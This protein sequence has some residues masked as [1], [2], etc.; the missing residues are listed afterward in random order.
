[1]CIVFFIL[2][3]ALL[4]IHVENFTDFHNFLIL[5]L[6]RNIKLIEILL[7]YEVKYKLNSIVAILV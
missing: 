5:I 3:F 2:L 4:E 7:N 6:I 1:M